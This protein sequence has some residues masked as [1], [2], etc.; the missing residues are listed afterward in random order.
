MEV[1]LMQSSEFQQIITELNE[2]KAE[3]KNRSSEKSVEYLTNPKVAKL[4]GCSIRT[5]QTYRDENRLK[6]YKVSRKILYKMSDVEEFL[7]K[8]YKTF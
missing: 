2:I 7:E 3:L 6:F 8:N 4:L 1:V 5:L